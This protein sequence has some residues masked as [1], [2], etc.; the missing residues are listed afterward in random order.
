MMD[1]LYSVVGFV[2]ALGILV[3][4]HEF[5]HFWVAR[6]LGVKVLRFSVGFGRPIWS[7]RSGP[8]ETEYVVAAIP[9][10]GYVKMLGEDDGEVAEADQ[11]RAFNRKSVVT[12][13]LIAVAGPGANFLFAILAYAAVFMVGV[14]G[15]QPVVGRVTPDSLAAH[16]G[17]QAGD[18]LLSVNGR[19]VQSWGEYRMYL[20]SRALAGDT[21]RFEVRDPDGGTAERVLDFGKVPLGGL[22][23]GFLEREVGLFG[24]FPAI[25]PLVGK[26][27][28]GGPAAQ[29]GVESGD[30]ITAVGGHPV[31]S[32]DDVV[33]AISK[34]P[35]QRLQI[36]VLR[37]G[38]TVDLEV[39]VE[40]A[41]AGGKTVGR[42]G[43]AVQPPQDQEI[44]A[45]M[46]TTV[47]YGP[48]TALWR[49]AEDTWTMSVITIKMLVKMLQLEVS[50]KNIS[51][52]LT[53]AQYAG[54]TA[55]VGLESFVMFLAVVS[56]SLG[57]L[58]LLP[59]PILDGGHL[60]Y[61]LG[62]A[63]YGGPLPKQVML[64]GQQIGILL[65]VGLMGLAFYN[66]L[67]RLLQ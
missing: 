38:T 47:R 44:P 17:F 37:D 1:L 65:L 20:F 43:I 11:D 45:D 16:S 9:L 21:V 26:V 51:G 52:P 31:S 50:A 25:P 58:N 36:S 3:T 29:A 67:A 62:E 18:R 19:P 24:Y 14:D 5:G 34:R 60:L 64:W 28:D 57:V 6:R 15:L 10:G 61:N 41:E 22:D 12:R 56:I 32:W 39:S 63:I 59:I 2:V 54:H 13:S 4:V 7:R 48:F 23:A 30:L 27:I 42:V 8:D 46:R 53:I 66:D 55:Q 49:G 33:S 35:G 40:A